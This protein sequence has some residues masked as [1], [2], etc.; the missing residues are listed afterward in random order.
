MISKVMR[1]FIG[2]LIISVVLIDITF[3]AAAQNKVVVIPLIETVEAPLVSLAPLAATSPPDT[4][5]ETLAIVGTVADNIMGLVWT[6]STSAPARW[7]AN[8]TSPASTSS[9]RC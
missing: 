6:K 1:Y 5:Y 3:E 2:A 8:R 7:A 4:A 9:R